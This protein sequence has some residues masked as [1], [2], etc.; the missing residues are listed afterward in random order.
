MMRM[1]LLGYASSA[2]AAEIVTQQQKIS[3]PT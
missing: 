1:D 3:K 2:R